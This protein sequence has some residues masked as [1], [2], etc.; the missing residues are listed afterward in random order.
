MV[1]TN[2]FQLKNL[3][4]SEKVDIIVVHL[5]WT[6]CEKILERGAVERRDGQ[7]LLTPF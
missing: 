1:T 4:M 2:R 6:A 5:P 3:R 7:V